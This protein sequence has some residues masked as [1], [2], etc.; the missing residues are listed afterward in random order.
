VSTDSKLLIDM[1]YTLGAAFLGALLATALKQSVIVGYVLAGVA[2]G[3][4]TPGFVADR[5]TMQGLANV[6]IVFLL[7]TIG[8]HI[9]PSD[10]FKMWRPVVVGGSI[11][12]AVTLCLG[13]LLG[14]MVGLSGPESFVLGAAISNSSSTVLGKVLSELGQQNS[15]AGRLAMAWSTF[16][17]L[18]T[19]V[20][21]VALAAV[22]TGSSNP[23]D[24]ALAL[25]RAMLFLAF[26]V[27]L[28]ATM[29][30]K[31]FNRLARLGSR[32]LFVLAISSLALAA[33][34]TSQFFGVSLALGA[35][36]AGI[37]VAESD[38]AHVVLD[39]I[40]PLRDVLSAFFFVSI[41][42]LIDPAFLAHNFGVILIVVATIL[43]VKGSLVA[44]LAAAFGFNRSTALAT[45]VYL[46][47]CAEFSLLLAG[48]GVEMG[49]V[50]TFTFSLI[51]TSS[52]VSV[53]IAP[54]L[55]RL[56]LRV[57]PSPTAIR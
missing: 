10:L 25:A 38:L 52:L 41:G 12:V 42:M 37:V 16:Q 26:L 31:I 7:F 43:V 36:V 33:A 57:L 1:A 27:P 29:L 39:H 46:A 53:V 22:A 9:S 32:E 20:L 6:G 34:Y 13:Y 50:S 3:P 45:A 30:P 54:L 11:Q 14:R 48:L 24:M 40:G 19:L 28:G 49:A 51:L 4:F 8:V 5:T 21:V 23:A 55:A 44:L 35:F 56:A 2:V 17:D 18:S 47:Q 15:H